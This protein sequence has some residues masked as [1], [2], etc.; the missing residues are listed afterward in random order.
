MISADDAT[1]SYFPSDKPWVE[2][3]D[4]LRLIGGCC[5]ACGA[6]S[7]P[8][9]D[10]CNSCEVGQTPQSVELAPQGAL[11]TYTELQVGPAGFPTPRLCGYVDMDDGIRLFGQIAA[12]GVSI[13][14]RLGLE[15]AQIRVMPDGKPLLSYRF[16]KVN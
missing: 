15:L 3:N 8:R 6:R 14:E 2:H 7:F 1:L 5:P 12:D 4:E 13:G 10:H 16:R 9:Q 11:Y